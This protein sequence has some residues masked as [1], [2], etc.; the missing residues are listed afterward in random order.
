MQ[1]TSK[2]TAEGLFNYITKTHPYTSEREEVKKFEDLV[3]KISKQF[4]KVPVSSKDEFPIH[5]IIV[6]YNAERIKE[7]KEAI[8]PKNLGL[9]YLMFMSGINGYHK[10]L[11]KSQS[12]HN[13]KSRKAYVMPDIGEA[14]DRLN[15]VRVSAK[16]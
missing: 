8:D 14:Y 15:K 10:S 1:S 11:S 6:A 13:L 4:Y 9:C 7:K 2:P 12:Q 3:R 5:N 16:L